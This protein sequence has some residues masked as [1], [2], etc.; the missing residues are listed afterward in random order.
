MLRNIYMKDTIFRIYYVS[1]EYTTGLTD[2]SILIKKEDGTVVLPSTIISELEEGIYY[3][4]FTP[5]EETTYIVTIDSIT[6][7][8][9][10]TQAFN[11]I[12]NLTN[13]SWS[14]M[15]YRVFYNAKNNLSG[16]TDV[17]IQAWYAGS[18][19]VTDGILT[20]SSTPGIYYYDLPLANPGSYVFTIDCVSNSLPSTKSIYV[21]DLDL[22][23]V[24]VTTAVDG[25]ARITNNI[26]GTV[27]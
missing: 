14:S 24:Y 9:R 15:L 26:S 4:D 16:L 13:L 3:Y 12:Q 6:K 7:P 11:I 1:D 2:V 21:Q 8:L 20:E 19:F 18:K 27:D 5:T 17:K 22:T 23:K 25:T 10:S